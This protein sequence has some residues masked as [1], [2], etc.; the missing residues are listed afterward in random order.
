[1]PIGAGQLLH[2]CMVLTERLE[3]RSPVEADR[4]R[5]VALF[6]DP[7][8]MEFSAGVHDLGSANTRAST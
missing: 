4:L 1:M 7:G 3:I 8:F 6:Q 5:F 2:T